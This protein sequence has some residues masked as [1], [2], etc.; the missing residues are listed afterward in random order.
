MTRV[1]GSSAVIW[2]EIRRRN[3]NAEHD[4]YLW[5]NTPTPYYQCKLKAQL[6]FQTV[7]YKKKL[8]FNIKKACV[9]E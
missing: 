7:T 2:L 8:I 9:D 6:F 1:F 3:L 5:L 4:L